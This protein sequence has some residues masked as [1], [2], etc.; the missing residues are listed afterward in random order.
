MNIDDLLQHNPC[1]YVLKHLKYRIHAFATSPTYNP[2]AAADA[3]GTRPDLS[4]L[5]KVYSA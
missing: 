3:E 5:I 4:D 1:D 2:A